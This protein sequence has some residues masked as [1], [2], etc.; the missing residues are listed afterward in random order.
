MKYFTP[1]AV[2][3]AV[4]DTAAWR[5]KCSEQRQEFEKIKHCFSEKFISEYEKSEFHD[6]MIDSI[7]LKKHTD[8]GKLFD[9]NITMRH[10]EK[11]L[12]LIYKD[13]TDFRCTMP[14]DGYLPFGDYILGELAQTSDGLLTHEFYFYD[15]CCSV[16]IKCKKITL[17]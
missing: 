5:K 7:L 3:G 1:E 10:D 17:K 16:Y 12:L 13:V 4:T 15:L 9:I 14:L 6:Y 11:Q 2:E 8:G